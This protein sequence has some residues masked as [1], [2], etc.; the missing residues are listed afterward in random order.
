MAPEGSRP[1]VQRCVVVVILA[2]VF[3]DA[4]GVGFVIPLFPVDA[5]STHA[6]EFGRGRGS[7]T[8]GRGRGS[9]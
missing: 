7:S 6:G 1:E 4:V 2:T 3:L 5:A 8:R 9:A